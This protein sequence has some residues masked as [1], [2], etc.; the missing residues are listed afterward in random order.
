MNLVFVN[1]QVCDENLAF[2][3]DRQSDR[4]EQFKIDFF[5]VFH[6]NQA[7]GLDTDG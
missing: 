4:T 7:G 5:R 1:C 2:C 6:K 3:P